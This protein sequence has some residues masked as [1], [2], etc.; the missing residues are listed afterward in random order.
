MLEV[1]SAAGPYC[2]GSGSLFYLRLDRFLVGSDV[3][4]NSVKSVSHPN[5]RAVVVNADRW[6]LRAVLDC[7]CQFLD[8]VIVDARSALRR[9]VR[10]YGV[11]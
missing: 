11:N 8:V 1:G 10:A 2:V 9:A 3:R 6:Q 4:Q 5:V 7:L